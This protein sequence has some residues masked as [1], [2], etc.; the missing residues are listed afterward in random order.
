MRCLFKNV[1]NT[2]LIA[3]FCSF[4]CFADNSKKIL[5][6]EF[7]ADN[8]KGLSDSDG[9]RSDWIELYNPG[10]V[11]VNLTGWSL[12]DNANNLKKWVFPSISIEA[13]QYLVVFASSKN[14][15]NTANHLH[16]S[17]SLSKD[18]EYLA[19]V[20]QNGTISDEYA[21][22]F[23]PQREDVS[24]G[25][26]DGERVFLT[27]PTPGA[28]NT[29]E[30]QALSPVFSVGRGFFDMPF[31]V[32]LTTNDSDTKIYYTTN[33]TRPTA[34]STLYTAP[35]NISTTTPLSA[36]GIKGDASS[37]IVTH[38]Y[39]F[40]ND[41]VKQPS[42]PAGYPNRWGV[43]GGDVR[44]SKYAVGE[45]APAHYA[46]NQ[47]VCNDSR[48][49]ADIRE[50]FL[51]I[52]TVSIVTNLSYLF[53]EAN[54]ANEGGIYIHTGVKTGD[55]WERPVSI[56]YYDPS[57]NKQFQIN[58]GLRL[59]GAAS[60]Q[61]EKN[62][63]HSF[64]VH[65]RKT[66][67]T[68]KLNFDL[69]EQET[70]V[71]QF[72]HLIF[73]AGFNCSWTHHS[74]NDRLHSQYVLDSFAKRTQRAMGH[75][76]AHDR[77]AHLFINGLYWGMYNISER[78]S[79]DFMESYFG[80]EAAD[81]DVINHDG[82]SD[83]QQNSFDRMMNLSQS[84][85]YNNLVSE[86]LLFMESYIDYLLINF[87]M[88]NWD[89]G[90]NNWYAARNRVN[91][92][93]GFRF[94]T[95]D[96][97]NSFFNGVNY[98]I[99]SGGA[100][101]GNS[102]LWKIMYGSSG[103]SGLSRNEEFKLL[104]ADRVQKH[105]FNGGAL[106]PE[107]TAELYEQLSEEIDKAIILESARWGSYRRDVLPGDGNQPLYTRNDHFYPKKEDLYK[108]YFPK[109]TEILYNQLQ[110]ASVI[111]NIKAPLFNRAGGTINSSIEIGITTEMGDIYYTTDGSDPREHGTGNVTSHA[112]K[113]TTPLQIAQTG[114]IKARAKANNTW[115]GLSEISFKYSEFNDV[116]TPA[117]RSFQMFY[118]SNAL[119]LDLPKEGDVQFA[120]YS[121]EG[122]CI[123]QGNVYLPDGKNRIGLQ[124][125]ERGIYIYKIYFNQETY[126]GKFGK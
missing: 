37:L 122:K 63:K 92:D 57:S 67:E 14:R 90:N 17:F 48:Y 121:I 35:I 18:G 95:W 93:G 56:E 46:M 99:V 108:K 91:A 4:S 111:P 2:L 42:I 23:P 26:Y 97:E 117:N 50:G 105:F 64:R 54:D 59:H 107:K 125:M 36:V 115:S 52:P 41:I 68:G 118:Y 19:I 70:A 120:I 66:Y 112:T 49:S 44:Y 5:I 110:S 61:P 94:F 31:T 76:S 109:R 104:F 101:F 81:Y 51:S 45:R 55:G 29:I 114:T 80:G 62:A 32:T 119:Y 38:T 13:G 82:L 89:W 85:N 39:L 124:N 21:P 28:A 27:T 72:N 8:S 77:F 12:T 25:Y 65:F 88:G 34:Q 113:Y 74:A 16:T 98:N 84:G 6:N 1:R 47:T 24:Y 96:S 33:G 123:Q 3:V 126:T 20:E 106:S 69:F 100:R 103:S 7:L 10:N 60:R 73:R 71:T 87:Y 75:Q 102:T 116:I 22:T 40:I 83:G 79:G 30:N 58:C 9:D 86:D 53:S 78:I 15:K 43:L 11:A